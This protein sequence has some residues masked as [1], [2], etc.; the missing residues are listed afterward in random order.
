MVEMKLDKIPGFASAEAIEVKNL[1]SYGTFS[2]QVPL[3]PHF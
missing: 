1:Q 3:V 2:F